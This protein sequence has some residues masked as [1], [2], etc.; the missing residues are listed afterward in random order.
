MNTAKQEVHSL[1]QNLSDDCT[2]E[3]VQYHLYVIGKIEK[4]I[5]RAEKEGVI[6]HEEAE[7][8][9]DKWIIK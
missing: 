9:L 8:R 4:S 7:R 3:D 2:L 6:P 5:R 1:L